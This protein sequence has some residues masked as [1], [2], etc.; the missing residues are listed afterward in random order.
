MTDKFII[1]RETEILKKLLE[2]IE[3]KDPNIKVDIAKVQD[4]VFKG[5]PNGEEKVNVLFQM[6]INSNIESEDPVNVEFT[7]REISFLKNGGLS[8]KNKLLFYALMVYS[9]VHP[10]ESGWINLDFYEV[11]RMA[12][13]EE[14]IESY[15]RE[16]LSDLTNF[17]L[18]FRVVGAKQAIPCFKLPAFDY[19][20][21]NKD[22]ADWIECGFDFT[23]QNSKRF[24]KEFIK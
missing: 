1:D 6:L 23:L 21:E 8:D 16:D 20:G 24:F 9:K 2:E 7:K 19:D 13:D 22:E 10:H 12:V 3:D 14:N 17:G 11:L 18:Q 4:K 5:I 15:R